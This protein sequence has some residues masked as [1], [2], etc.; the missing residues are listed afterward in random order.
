MRSSGPA[1]AL[2]HRPAAR[3]PVHFLVDI[4]HT[5][6]HPIYRHVAGDNSDTTRCSS[7]SLPPA[8]ARGWWPLNY[9]GGRVTHVQLRPHV[10]PFLS[11]V[12]LDRSLDTSET[13]VHVSLYTRQSAAY[14]AAIA[15]QVLLPALAQ[16]KGEPLHEFRHQEVFHELFGGEHCVRGRFEAMHWLNPSP[17]FLSEGSPADQ[18]Q[19]GEATASLEWRKTIFVLPSPLTTLLVDDHCV[20]FRVTELST[21]HGVLVPPYY[22]DA[23]ACA[24]D[25]CF[26]VP[27]TGSLCDV[28]GMDLD[29]RGGCISSGRAMLGRVDVDDVV[30]RLLDVL[31]AFVQ[32]CHSHRSAIE[33]MHGGSAG[34]SSPDERTPCAACKSAGTPR[35]PVDAALSNFNFFERSPLYRRQWNAFHAHRA[36]FLHSYFAG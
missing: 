36:D 30:V 18:R 23:V 29:R 9:V 21:G 17:G 32:C 14:C 4:D 6:V 28:I 22:A 34:M 2:M 7:A 1:P 25:D 10:V 5:L 3:L 15:Y 26:R 8:S 24:A 33:A 31:E 11:H 20:N 35:P 16:S 13:Q 12:L 27:P 19:L